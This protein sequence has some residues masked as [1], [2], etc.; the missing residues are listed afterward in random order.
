VIACGALKR[1]RGF[2]TCS[3]SYP[4]PTLQPDAWFPTTMAD[5]FFLRSSDPI[6]GRK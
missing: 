4:V 6:K 1:L 2:L 5:S 3:F